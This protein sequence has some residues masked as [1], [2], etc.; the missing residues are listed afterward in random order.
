MVLAYNKFELKGGTNGIEN[1]N[2]RI[3]KI[4]RSNLL[5]TL[6][7]SESYAERQGSAAREE[8][9]SRAVTNGD[10]SLLP[11]LHER[12]RASIDRF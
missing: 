4:M 7:S 1:Y 9:D 6:A 10:A 5:Q 12:S 2:N 3:M 11:I 8:L